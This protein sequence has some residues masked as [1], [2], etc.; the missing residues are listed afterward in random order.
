MIRVIAC[1]AATFAA[2]FAA[3]AVAD[4]LAAG[5]ATCRAVTD[6]SERLACYDELAPS[7]VPIAEAAAPPLIH[8]DDVAEAEPAAAPLILDDDVAKTEV[9]GAKV[10]QP[11]YAAV[12]TRC[13]E[14]QHE[15]RLY[16]FMENG[17]VWKQSNSKRIRLKDKD[18]Q[19]EVTVRKDGFGWILR[20]PSEDRRIRVRRVR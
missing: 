8:D 17:Q 10:E 18:C 9:K 11:E 19:F 5:L 6:E 14:A 3:T 1:A 4:D 15:R 12:V 13:E 2:L 7:T 16:F 20:I